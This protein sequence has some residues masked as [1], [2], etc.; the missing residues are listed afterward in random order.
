MY[1]SLLFYISFVVF[2]MDIFV[3]SHCLAFLTIEGCVY[4]R[5]IKLYSQPHK[6]KNQT[7]KF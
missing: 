7:N 1:W 6:M 5:Y 4:A 2:D 3:F